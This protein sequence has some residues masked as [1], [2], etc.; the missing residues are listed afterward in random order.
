MKFSPEQERQLRLDLWTPQ[1]ADDPL[2]FVRYVYPWGKKGTPLEHFK[3][4]RRW[5]CEDL[6]EIGQHIA[7]NKGRAAFD[8]MPR[9]FRKSTVSGRGVGK[10]AMVAWIEHWFMTTR[11]GSS[12]IITA[13]T[14]P[15]LRTKTWPELGK[16]LTL[17]LNGHWFDYQA[18][19]IKPASWFAEAVKRDL[20]IDCGYYYAQAQTWSEENPDAFAGAHN[21]HGMLVVMDEAS[22]IAANIMS[23]TEGFFTEP[24]HDRYWLMFSNGRRNSGY[25]YETH[26]PVS[27]EADIWRKRQLDSRTVE[28]T[29]PQQ[30][31]TIIRKY[32]PDSDEARVEVYG[33]FPEEGDDQFISNGLVDAAQRRDDR[34][35]PG[36]ALVM[37]VDIA[38]LGRDSTV[39]RWRQG[40][41]GRSVRPVKLHG[42]TMDQQE[43]IIAQLITETDPDGVCIDAGNS[44]SGLIDHLRRR[45]Y[46]IEE[47][48]FGASATDKE[49]Y[50]DKITECYGEL[51][52]WLGNGGC[53]DDDPELFHDL[54]AREKRYAGKQKD[55]LKLE[56]KDEYRERGNKSPD[57]G[58]ALAITFAKKFARRDRIASRNRRRGDTRRARNVDYPIFGR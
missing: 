40:W 3:G 54:T 27:P 39:I 29:D 5:Q 8:E 35:D 47:V 19:S 28:G 57:N 34:K 15:Q 22:G 13:N 58:D 53:I 46:K 49:R 12:T 14:E 17:A 41:D 38:R 44:G 23:V 56:P 10:S 21:P 33:Q 42:K 7:D 11:I 26:H 4:P 31:D 1:L 52:D 9:M 24:T 45:G 36:A 6:D 37:G 16:W 20:K 32:G 2:R 30:Y 25:F 18:L 48:W 55:R 51:R 50:D 43:D